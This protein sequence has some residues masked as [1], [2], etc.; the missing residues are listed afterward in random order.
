[1]LMIFLRMCA[2]AAGLSAGTMWP[3][4]FTQNMPNLSTALL[5]PSWNPF[6]IKA[7]RSAVKYA[8]RPDQRNLSTQF[9]VPGVATIRSCC[10]VI[11]T[12]FKLV[13]LSKRSTVIKEVSSI[14]KCVTVDHE[15]LPVSVAGFK[16]SSVSALKVSLR[17][18]PH[19]TVFGKFNPDFTFPFM[20]RANFASSRS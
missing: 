16:K 8:F 7:F 3:A 20:S 1:M 14:R 5:Y 2:I 18:P 11:T 9:T 4:R 6:T 15:P 10:P 17:C 12:T 19:S 13:S